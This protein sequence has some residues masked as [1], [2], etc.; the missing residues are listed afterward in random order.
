MAGDRPAD[1]SPHGNDAGQEHGTQASG[2]DGAINQGILERIFAGL[3]FIVDMVILR[4][5][6]DLSEAEK[7][8]HL[9][10]GDKQCNIAGK[11]CGD[12]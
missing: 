8:R 6:M 5:I 10:I 7:Q 4:C 1:S 11:A 3:I 2:K 9:Y 12:G